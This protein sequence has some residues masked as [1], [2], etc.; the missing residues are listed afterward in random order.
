MASRM[1]GRAFGRRILQAAPSAS[2]R[3]AP[4]GFAGAAP[5]NPVRSRIF[6]RE[7]L[8]MRP[9]HSATADC[10]MV[11]RISG[12]ATC[13]EGGCFRHLSQVVD[14]VPRE[15]AVGGNNMIK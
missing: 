4:F 11:S 8:S 5:R 10:W 13:Y 7:L 12:C 9:L 6:R 15:F 2:R 3:S 1:A 14:D